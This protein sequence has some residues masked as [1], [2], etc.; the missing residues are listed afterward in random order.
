MHT[1][2]PDTFTVESTKLD[3]EPS[4]LGRNLPSTAELY[5]TVQLPNITSTKPQRL[6]P[7][8]TTRQLSVEASEKDFQTPDLTSQRR[9]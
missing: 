4:L 2:R 9:S 1:Y 8:A 6:L 5:T 7:V 3:T